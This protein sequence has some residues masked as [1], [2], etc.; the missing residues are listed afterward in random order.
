MRLPCD[1]LI[2]LR[3]RMATAKQKRKLTL[4]E[5]QSIIGLLNFACAVVVPGRTFMHRLIDLTIGL[6]KPHHK[7][8][9]NQEAKADLDVWSIFIS[10]FNG[11]AL[12]LQEKWQ[13]SETLHLFTDASG[14][15]FGGIFGNKWFAEAWT[16][17]REN[18]HI[19]V[20]ELFP[21]TVAVELWGVDVANRKICFFSDNMAVVQVINKQ[22]ARDKDLMRLLR[23]LVAQCLTFNILFQSK[24]VPGIKNTLSDK[25]SR[26][27]ISQF[28]A[29]A[30]QM[31]L[32]PTCVPAEMYKIWRKYPN[33]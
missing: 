19:S 25:L 30:P 17:D 1:K 6:K 16:D 22:T 21:I 32:N 2:K 33:F 4:Q 5:L 20:K 18:F 27:Q 11:S 9:L 12:F 31:E 14:L 15:G 23:R 13:T 7:R 26:L 28:H 8:Y 24:H 29:L 10:H 3:E